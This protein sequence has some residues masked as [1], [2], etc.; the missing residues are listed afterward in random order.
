MGIHRIVRIVMRIW[1]YQV[2]LVMQILILGY[3]Y[4]VGKN[5]MRD[6]YTI[7][8]EAEC[9][10]QHATVLAVEI[11]S[12]KNDIVVWGSDPFL[13]EKFAREH[14][15]MARPGEIVYYR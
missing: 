4:S 10:A 11:E 8:Q 2:G 6:V 7:K 5:G 14:L 15:H 9:A 3:V 12:R 1:M 13:Q